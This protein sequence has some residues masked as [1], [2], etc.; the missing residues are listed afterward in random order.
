MSSGEYEKFKSISDSQSDTLV[1]RPIKQVKA[2]K[3]AL[4]IY[5]VI[6][7]AVL[8]AAIIYFVIKHKDLFILS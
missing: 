6:L 8:I 5:I 4:I 3:V 7:L 2:S 1:I